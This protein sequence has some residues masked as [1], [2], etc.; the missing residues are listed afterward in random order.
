MKCVLT[1]MSYHN[2]HLHTDY[3]DI[4][5]NDMPVVGAPFIFLH[6]RHDIHTSP[7]EYVELI[8]STCVKFKTCTST[9]L[10]IVRLETD[11]DSSC[12]SGCC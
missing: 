11:N 6:K 7:V 12:K 2:R 4:I 1:K 10:L 5:C 3:M 8:S 9:Y